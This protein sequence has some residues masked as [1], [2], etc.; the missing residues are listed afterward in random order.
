MS[1]HKVFGSV[2]C[3]IAC[4]SWGAMFPVADRAFEQIHPFYFSII[5]YGAVSVLL[6]ALLWWK[7]GVRAFRLEGR[8]K[9]LLFYGTMAFTVYNLLIFLGQYA[10]GDAGTVAASIMEAL[11]PVI[12][13]LILWMTTKS[14]P[15]G[16]LLATVG[17]ALVGALLVITKGTIH[18]HPSLLRHIVP[19]ALILAGVVGWVIYSFGTSKFQHWSA[20]RYSTITCCLGTAVSIVITMTGTL[21]GWMPAP[22]LQ[23]VLSI[24][25]EMAFM[26]VFPGIIALL[27]WNAGLKMISTVNGIL[28]INLVPITTF[29]MMAAQGYRISISEIV[30][31]AMIVI[32]LVLN[33]LF[34][35]EN[36]MLNEAAH[37]KG[38]QKPKLEVTEAVST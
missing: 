24:K 19:V 16:R 10:M 37:G 28:Y 9:L 17:L 38:K 21:L 6:A 18:L 34:R 27:G 7:E 26:I 3:M 11:M 14:R 12:S 5:R 36:Q 29:G 31:T 22:G 35:R 4:I 13:I 1:K 15:S 23:A 30:G 33:S 32:A 8:G 20:L 25:Y 2:L